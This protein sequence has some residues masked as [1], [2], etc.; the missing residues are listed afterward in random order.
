MNAHARRSPFRRRDAVPL[1]LALLF[2]LVVLCGLSYSRAQEAEKKE[3]EVVDRI[4]KHLPIKVK[5][6]KPE[7]L[8]DAKNDDWLDDM[9]LEVTNTGTKP[10]Y[11]LSISL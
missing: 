4:P 7:K 1:I 3:R 11:C 10:I 9:E 5:V 8:K 2:P 6:K